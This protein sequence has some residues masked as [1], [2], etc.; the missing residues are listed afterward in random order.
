[1][2]IAKAFPSNF[3]KASDFDE[4]TTYTIKGVTIETVG[5]GKDA[6]DKP[7]VSFRETD[8]TFIL[9]KTNSNTIAGLYGNETDQWVGKQI[10]LYPTEVEYQG[11]MTLSIRVRMKKPSTSSKPAASAVPD[12][13]GPPDALAD[14]KVEAWNAF[15]EKWNDFEKENPS[16]A[17][18]RNTKWQ[19]ACLEYAKFVQKNLPDLTAADYKGMAAQI[20]AD[21][22]VATG[23]YLP[24]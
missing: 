15:L 1:M 10:V 21:F 20:T 23:S 2:N 16:E 17:A 11:K 3:V 7:V 4:D 8:K 18:S 9:N 6:E 5:Q 13:F 22:H 14:A 24:I 19:M 12:P